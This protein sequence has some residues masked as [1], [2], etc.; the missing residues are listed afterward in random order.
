MPALAVG[1]FAV[2]KVKFAHSFPYAIAHNLLLLLPR[3]RPA[4]L[5]TAVPLPPPHAPVPRGKNIPRGGRA[6]SWK[7]QRLLVARERERHRRR[8]NLIGHGFPPPP[9]LPLNDRV[10]TQ[11]AP[12]AGIAIKSRRE[13]QPRP[14]EER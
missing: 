13:I 3:S 11:A 1:S 8:V 2:S 9:F 7:L 4:V 14:N 10:V 12:F 5:V 6:E